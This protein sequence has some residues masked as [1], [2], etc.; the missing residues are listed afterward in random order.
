MIFSALIEA[1]DNIQEAIAVSTMLRH[2][3]AHERKLRRLVRRIF[4][5]QAAAVA[6]TT[7]RFWPPTDTTLRTALRG[8]SMVHEAAFGDILGAAYT[9]GFGDG[10]RE[11]KED[12]EPSSVAR[13]MQ[14]RAADRISG[15]DETTREQLRTLLE[16]AIGENWSYTKI[17]A[18]I[19]RLFADFGRAVPQRHLRDR[20]ELIAV[21]ET[22][23]AFMDGQLEQARQR[24][25]RGIAIE[26]S[27]LTVGDDRVSE[28]C[29]ANQ[30]KGWID[31]GQLFPSGHASPLRFPGCRC[32]MQTRRKAA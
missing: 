30:A 9:Q 22:G 25:A 32:A 16:A 15:I 11:L 29:Q 6:E 21:T 27:W 31:F 8:V 14:R 18:A 12:L 23:Q 17:A 4:R 26:K 2:R 7:V 13:E 20:A 19:R 24:V 3:R 10:E 1:L 28:G 5:E